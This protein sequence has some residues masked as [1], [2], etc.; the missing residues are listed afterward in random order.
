MK[1]IEIQK[2]RSWVMSKPFLLMLIFLNIFSILFSVYRGGLIVWSLLN[3]IAVLSGILGYCHFHHKPYYKE[4]HL[5]L[6]SI[7]K[8]VRNKEHIIVVS[9]TTQ[10]LKNLT[11]EK[12][13]SFVRISTHNLIT[14]PTFLMLKRAA[15]IL[16]DEEMIL[17]RAEFQFKQDE[18]KNQLAREAINNEEKQ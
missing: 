17:Y 16:T 8:L 11:N 15:D 13:L 2:I 3:I 1:K 14:Y 7:W 6:K 5:R 9:A 4:L 12:G 10:D 18:Y